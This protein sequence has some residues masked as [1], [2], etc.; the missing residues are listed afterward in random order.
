M[1][2]LKDKKF[3]IVLLV[4]S[5]LFIYLTLNRENSKFYTIQPFTEIVMNQGD[6]IVATNKYGTI[7]IEAGKDTI[8]YY[9]WNNATRKVRL[10]VR[11]ERWYGSLGLY[12]SGGILDHFKENDGVTRAVVQEG[13]Q[14]FK[15]IEEAMNWIDTP[16]HNNIA[17]LVYSNEG[18]VVGWSKTPSRE[19]INVDVWQIYIN[20]EKPT[21]LPDASDDKIYF[22]KSTSR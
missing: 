21:N 13:Q 3:I 8:R 11:Y 18:L 10:S 7:Q 16:Y 17:D 14:H 4:I 12:S 22:N 20:G 1:G 5:L 2:F 6:R 19:Q 9:T 15:S